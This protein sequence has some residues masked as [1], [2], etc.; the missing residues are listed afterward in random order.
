MQIQRFLFRSTAKELSRGRYCSSWNTVSFLACVN[1]GSSHRR[2]SLP[3]WGVRPTLATS[4]SSSHAVTERTCN[5]SARNAELV[6]VRFIISTAHL[7]LV[8]RKH[9]LGRV[10][11][12]DGQVIDLRSR[13][14]GNQPPKYVPSGFTGVQDSAWEGIA[15]T[16][17]NH[18]RR[19][20][21]SSA[22]SRVRLPSCFTSPISRHKPSRCSDWDWAVIGRPASIGMTGSEAFLQPGS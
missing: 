10:Y 8:E 21:A 12:L 14:R 15:E 4:I 17:P 11:G 20:R 9:N 5:A 19:L 16:D 13:V 18:L 7:H 6:P 2:S 3:R 1:Q 22:I